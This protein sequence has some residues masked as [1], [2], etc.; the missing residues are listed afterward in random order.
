MMLFLLRSSRS[1]RCRSQKM[2][3][4]TDAR[5]LPERSRDFKEEESGRRSERRRSEIWLSGK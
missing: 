3:S 4:G 5:E 2:P 1:S